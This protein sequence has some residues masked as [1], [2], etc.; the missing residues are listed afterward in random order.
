MLLAK[1]IFSS[2]SKLIAAAN[3]AGANCA[4]QNYVVA[5]RATG[6]NEYKVKIQLYCPC[7]ENKAHLPINE[8]C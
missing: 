5:N 2:V 4:G 1:N 7:H 8:K 6:E 3:R